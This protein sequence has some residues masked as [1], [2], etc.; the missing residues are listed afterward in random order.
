MFLVTMDTYSRVC[1]GTFLGVT[2]FLAGEQEDI[3]R[4]AVA[5]QLVSLQQTVHPLDH[6]LQAL[7]HV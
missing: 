4:A 7:V 2:R 5:L 1:L 3:L 6:T